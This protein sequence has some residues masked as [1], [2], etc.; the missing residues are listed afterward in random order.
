MSRPTLRIDEAGKPAK[1]REQRRDAEPSLKGTFASVMLLGG[2]LL[3]TW[4]AVFALYLIR[5]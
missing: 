5:N 2:F 3:V 4:L 1:A